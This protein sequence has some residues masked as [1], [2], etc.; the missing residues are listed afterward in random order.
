MIRCIASAFFDFFL[1]GSPNQFPFRRVEVIDGG[2]VGV[3]SVFDPGAIML[4]GNIRELDAGIF[5]DLAKDVLNVYLLERSSAYIRKI[6]PSF[7]E[8]DFLLFSHNSDD[9]GFI[10]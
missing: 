5:V 10:K 6:D 3:K 4:A 8:F 1:A 7:L 9:V 2:G